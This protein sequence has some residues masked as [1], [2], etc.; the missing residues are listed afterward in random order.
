M[1]RHYF[2]A[3]WASLTR[4]RIYSLINL[5]GLSLGIAA[6]LIILLHVRYEL[7]Y[8]AWLPGADRAFV[9]Q[10]WVT[11]SDDPNVI[12]GAN[13]MTSFVSGERLRQFPQLDRVVYVGNAQPVI[14]QNGEATVSEDFVFVDGPLFDIL[15]IPFLR[16]D[17]ATAL[18]SPGSLVLTESEARRRFG[19]LDAVGRT[20]T[21]VIAGQPTDYR[22][23]GIVQDPRRN[24]HL[25]LSVVA[26][27]DIVALYG[28]DSPFLTQWMPKNGWVYARLRP[29]ADLGEIARQMPA[30]ERRNI[31]DQMV[32]GE[33]VNAGANVDWRML[34][35]RDIH[36]GEA[37]GG[38]MR[39]GNDKATVAAMAL[40]GLLILAMAVV[41]FVNLATARAGQRAREV[42][43]RKVLGASRRQL[44]VQFL[45]E[46]LLLASVALLGALALVE[47]A[48]PFLN[49]FL[50]A[51]M[52]VTWFGTDGILLPALVLVLVVGGLGGLYPAFYLSGFRPARV[53]K[54][55][56]ASADAEGSGRL[57]NALV[58][59][60][61]AVSIGLIICT[62][63]IQAQ[64][65]YARTADPGYRRDGILQ[66]GQMYRAALVPR[67]E[68][69]L[70]EIQGVDGVVSTGRS[71]I[72]VD[73]WGMENMTVTA[74]GAAES[75][76]FELYRVDPGFFPTLG[77]APIAGRTFAPGV[78]MDDSTLDPNLP[79]D[80]A[81]TA[82]ARRGYNVVLNR[83]AARRLG[84]TD[85]RQ[86]VGKTLLADGGD[87]ETVGRTPVTII[88]VVD[89]SRFRSV[90]DPLAPMM[91]LYERFQPSWLLVR[92]HGNPR[93]VRDR[94][95]RVWKR[96][97]PD[98]PFEAEFSDDIVQDLYAPEAARARIFA[99][100]A[101]LAVVIGCLGLFG[102]A[103][104]TAERRT[105]EIGIRKV[106]GAR[107]R[108]ILRLLV[109]QFSRLVLLAN[110]IA[111]P[112]AWWAMRDWLNGFD[113]RIA[114]DPLLF[115]GAGVLA[116]LIAAATVAGQTLKVA[117]AHPVHAL[118]YE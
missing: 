70:R 56:R 111:W 112:V 26:R 19:T 40:V 90:R 93:D 46:S 61:F 18:A 84:F 44:I 63:I 13:P 106:L 23:T 11:A 91:F 117:R 96:V 68:T 71:T 48:L 22:V 59:G 115:V 101:L 100:F 89:N 38:G 88:G 82:M 4:S 55:N 78:A 10:Q 110:L 116:L 35:V 52:K 1:W 103:A 83:L 104:F 5:I 50:D 16:G 64:T 20:L 81:A 27:A 8:D 34:N 60:Q 53:L 74:P 2:R 9:L 79:G 43:L 51:D 31:P 86:A 7:S 41:N 54:A 105:K 80:E 114:L 3:G 57:R 97:A 17:R 75:I 29:G 65:D 47:A 72:G 108:D 67:L 99:A 113:L 73:T 95:E 32:G 45:G 28:A 21:L 39:P 94:I 14:L 12:P 58:V 6:S 15:Q 24:S 76:E 98:V 42:A 49:A 25:A 85:A 37:D 30:W 92:Y 87:V 77:I 66:I 33:R 107:T 102:L 118:R 109:W 62:A 69:L 36:L